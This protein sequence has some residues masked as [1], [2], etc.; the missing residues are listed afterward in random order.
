MIYN[1]FYLKTA[2]LDAEFKTYNID[3]DDLFFKKEITGFCIDSR[4]ITRDQIFIA[5]LGEQVD[6]HDYLISVLQNGAMGLIIQK[7]KKELLDKIDAKLL[8]E[9]LVIIVDDTLHALKQLAKIWRNRFKYPI[10]G[11]TGSVGKTSTKEMLNSIFNA[12]SIFAYVSLENQNT[13][14]GLSLNILKMREEH[15]FAVFEMGISHTGEMEE[16]V[17]LLRPTIGV[18]TYISNAHG[19][20]LGN[21]AQITEEKLKIFS[22][23]KSN[24]V[25]IINGDQDVF[26]EFYFDFPIITFGL[27]TKNNIQAR[28]IKNYKDFNAKFNLKIHSKKYPL[29]APFNHL[30]LINN[31]LAATAVAEILEID[32]KFIVSGIENYKSFEGRFEKKELKNNNGNLIH[33]CYNA[34]PESMKVALESFA[35][36]YCA[37]K[38]IA[39]LGDM[40]ELGEK[41]AFW[42]KQVGRF[43]SK[44]LDLDFI[45]LVGNLSVNICKTMPAILKNKTKKVKDW[46]QA[47]VFLDNYL[48]DFSNKDNLILFKASRGV[49]LDNII[50]DLS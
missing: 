4:K 13:I 5:L 17:D 30:G 38:K 1:Q 44:N 47:K 7:D 24:N 28:M 23:F 8:E 6:G 35:K 50:K 48:K 34:S 36:I 14:I 9:K 10:V 37:G 49:G 16:L 26:K 46:S 41:E 32:H 39:V 42:H 25:A 22:L 31:V 11:V 21:L 18:I 2:L 27:K 40:L 45:L 43:L 12:A 3:L 33:D 20:G 29:I 19:Q 15:K